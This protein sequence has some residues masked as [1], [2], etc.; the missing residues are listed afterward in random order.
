MESRT[1]KGE[2]P[3]RVK[4]KTESKTKSVEFC[5]KKG[6]PPSKSKYESISD[7]EKY[8]EGKLKRIWEQK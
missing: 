3:K 7:R 6:G 2:S 8:R 5:Q 1:K 4:E